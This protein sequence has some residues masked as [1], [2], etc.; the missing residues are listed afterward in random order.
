[1]TAEQN[2][3]IVRRFIDEFQTA[4]DERAAEELL[5]ADFV[6]RTPFS[7]F[8][9]DRQGFQKF[10]TMLRSAFPDM[11]AEVYAQ[12]AEGDLVAT[13]KTLRGTHT[14]EV[15]GAAPTGRRIAFDVIDVVRVEKG[16]IAEQWNVVDRLGLMQQLGLRPSEAER[17]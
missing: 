6:D 5:A 11:R 14:G 13:R 10:F 1:M 15:L 16:R 12:V 4:G 3:L 17:G 8:A 7:G 2:K 9:A